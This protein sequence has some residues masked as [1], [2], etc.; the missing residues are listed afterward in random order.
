MIKL[1]KT[2]LISTGELSG[3]IYAADL[4]RDLLQR[5]PDFRLR[6]MGS[7]LLKNAGVEIVVDTKDLSLIGALAIIGKINKIWNAFK[8]MRQ[9]IYQKPDLLILVDYPGFNIFLAR[10]AKRAGVKILYYI[11]PKIW[12][13]NFRR[14]KTIKAVVNLMAV[15][16]PFEV[17][18]YRSAN[19]PVRF[20]GNPLLKFITNLTYTKQQF[21]E[22]AG[23]SVHDPVV[24]LFPGSRPGEI[25]RLLPVILEATKI[26]GTENKTIQFILARASSI[27]LEYLNSYLANFSIPIKIISEQSYKIMKMADVILSA[28]GTATLE[29]ILIGTPLVIIYKISW[30]EY[31]IAKRLIKVPYVGL[32]NILAGKMVV[33]ELLQNEASPENIA[34]ILAKILEDKQYMEQMIAEFRQIK[35]S[36][37][38]VEATDL[39]SIVANLI[40]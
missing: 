26:L 9:A 21:R 13:W 22:Q 28:S 25:K 32:G 24:A 30:F 33:P 7:N 27:S 29:A 35:E 20:V 40:D 12:A 31:Q 16:F 38:A 10:I 37:T 18:L 11:G 1:K 19:V 8:L 15:I 14:I 3:E 2:I 36:L 34:L 6:G 4:A 39:V 5:Y 23:I 17:D